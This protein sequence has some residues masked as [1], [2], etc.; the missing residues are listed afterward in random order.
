MPRDLGEELASRAEQMELQKRV[1]PERHLAHRDLLPQLRSPD[2]VVG[3]SRS[4]DPRMAGRFPA[5]RDRSVSLRHH[6]DPAPAQAGGTRQE[7][8]AFPQALR[9]ARLCSLAR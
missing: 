4:Q 5:T 1:R 9:H 6:R 8:S 7:V 2:E 3:V